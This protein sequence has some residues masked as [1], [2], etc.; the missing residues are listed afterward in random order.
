MKF[1]YTL[2]F[3]LGA[4]NWKLNSLPDEIADTLKEFDIANSHL[5][6]LGCGVGKESVELASRGWHVIGIDFI[7]Q[8]VRKAKKAAKKVQVNDLTQFIT[9]DVSKLGTVDLPP[10]QFA[11]DIGCF[12]LLKPDQMAGYIAGINEALTSG[13]VF[14]LN[15]FTPRQQGNKTI[16]L[17][18]EKIGELFNPSFGLEKISNRSYWRYPAN[19]YWLRKS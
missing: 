13:G 8:A 15:A 17:D 10:I 5:L 16:G 6:D 3:S 11:Y 12:H 1:L 4:D 2:A 18:P 19:W 14:L 9:A 7:P